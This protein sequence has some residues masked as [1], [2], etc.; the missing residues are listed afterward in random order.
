MYSANI[1]TSLRESVTPTEGD[2]DAM[3]RMFSIDPPN[4]A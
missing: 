4:I 1:V 3:G 2:T